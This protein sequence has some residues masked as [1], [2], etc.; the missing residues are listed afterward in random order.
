MLQA[1]KDL[2]FNAKQIKKICCGS[3]FAADLPANIKLLHLMRD[4]FKF[5]PEQIKKFCANATFSAGP[6]EVEDFVRWLTAPG[7][8]GFTP[9]DASRMRYWCTQ[10][11]K[12]KEE[13]K[14]AI[15]GCTGLFDRRDLAMQFLCDSSYVPLRR[16]LLPILVE[17]V[18][19]FDKHEVDRVF[20]RRIFRKATFMKRARE[21]CDDLKDLKESTDFKEKVDTLWNQQK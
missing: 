11:K 4:E 14:A 3:F 7:D 12:N 18:P 10:W 19:L 17:M 20:L 13:V 15:L 9:A 5:N 6:A 21:I 1:L 8:T 2:K 16:Q